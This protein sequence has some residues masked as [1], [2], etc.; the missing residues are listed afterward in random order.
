M[1]I[2]FVGSI[3]GLV[4]PNLWSLVPMPNVSFNGVSSVR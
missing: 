3:V 4:L 2:M 1:D